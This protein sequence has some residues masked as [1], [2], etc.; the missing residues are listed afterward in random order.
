VAIL[1]SRLSR[2]REQKI[3]TGTGYGKESTEASYRTKEHQAVNVL[4]EHRKKG[5]RGAIAE[6]IRSVPR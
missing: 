2:L 6:V 3:R 5:N 4:L 1:I